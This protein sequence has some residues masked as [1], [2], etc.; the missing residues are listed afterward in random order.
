M[1][2]GYFYAVVGFDERVVLPQLKLFKKITLNCEDKS[3][4][5]ECEDNRKVK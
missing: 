5:T 2:Q 4:L 1:F 3:A